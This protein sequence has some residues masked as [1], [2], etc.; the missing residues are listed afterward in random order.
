MTEPLLFGFG[1]STPDGDSEF[2]YHGFI[3]GGNPSWDGFD[4]G[5]DTPQEAKNRF[6]QD[7][8]KMLNHFGR[9]AEMFWR[10]IPKLVEEKDL[11][12]ETLTYKYV[13]RVAVKVR[14]AR[15]D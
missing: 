7:L 11:K 13:G 12:K 4:L 2:T 15:N 5:F 1:D 6:L 9:G 14:K 8:E 10:R 3:L